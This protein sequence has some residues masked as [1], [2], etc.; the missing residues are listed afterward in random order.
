MW[1]Q[2]NRVSLSVGRCPRLLNMIQPIHRWIHLSANYHSVDWV[3]QF[4]VC[5][6]SEVNRCLLRAKNN[7]SHSRVRTQF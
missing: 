2:M 7:V 4:L 5:Q 1:I 3:S 6:R